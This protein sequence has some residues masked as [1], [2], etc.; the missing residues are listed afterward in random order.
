MFESVLSCL[1][2]DQVKE[3]LDDYV[4]SPAIWDVEAESTHHE[5]SSSM[6]AWATQRNSVSN[7]SKAETS[8]YQEVLYSLSTQITSTLKF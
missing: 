8:S 7:Q 4:Y 6:P 5:L 3:N 1:N 2:L